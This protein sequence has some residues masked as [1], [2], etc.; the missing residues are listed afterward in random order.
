MKLHKISLFA[1]LITFLFGCAANQVTQYTPPKPPP[2]PPPEGVQ[3]GQTMFVVINSIPS[4]ADVFTVETSS[5]D[6]RQSCSKGEKLGNTPLSVPIK[7][8]EWDGAVWFKDC[9]LDGGNRWSPI[10]EGT[11]HRVRFYVKKEGYYGVWVNTHL[12]FADDTGKFLNVGKGDG[13]LTDGYRITL[14]KCPVK[15]VQHG[16]E[17]AKEFAKAIEQRDY[18]GAE[19]LRLDRIRTLKGRLQE[20]KDFWKNWNG[21]N[22]I[23]SDDTEKQ[24]MASELDRLEHTVGLLDPILMGFRKQLIQNLNE[25]NIEA[26]LGL[27]QAV[28]AMEKKYF[29]EPKSVVVQSQQIPPGLTPAKLISPEPQAPERIVVQQKPYYGAT[30]LVE[31]LAAMRGSKVSPE[32][33]KKALGGAQLLDILGFSNM[34]NR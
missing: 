24:L 15:L 14:Y 6:N 11:A 31:A 5:E 30:H 19:E 9:V 2:Q 13:I 17:F 16:R 28:A 7:Y 26:A 22:S 29:P 25:G 1:F 10:I 23:G 18:Y 4:A 32:A 27:A 33:Y 20:E 3:Y 34:L 12:Y 21:G 8:C